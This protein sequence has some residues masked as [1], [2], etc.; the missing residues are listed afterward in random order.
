VDRA[1]FLKYIYSTIV[2]LSRIIIE[3]LVYLA[4][5]VSLEFLS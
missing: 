5:R 2:K 4:R 1:G 3:F